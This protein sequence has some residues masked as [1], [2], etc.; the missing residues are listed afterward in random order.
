VADDGQ[1]AWFALIDAAQDARLQGLVESCRD[2]A[3][4]YAGK[5]DPAVAAVAPWLARI[6]PADALLPTWQ[7][8]GRGLN[9]GL[10]IEAQV[11]LADLRSKLRRFTRA[12]LPDGQIVLFRFYDPRVFNTFIRAA[13]PEERAPWFEGGITQYAVEDDG[14]A[15]MRQYRLSRGRLMDGHDAIA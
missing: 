2:H 7:T 13:T 5:L 9:W 11:T 14:G 8:H 6:D 15:T 12:K 10:M 4:L 1:T 3:C